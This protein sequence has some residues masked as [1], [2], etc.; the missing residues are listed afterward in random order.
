M[1]LFKIRLRTRNVAIG[2]FYISVRQQFEPVANR[3]NTS[4]YFEKGFS[5]K[6]AAYS[7]IFSEYEVKV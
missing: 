2:G 1:K 6:K 4:K 5:E 3:S 7:D